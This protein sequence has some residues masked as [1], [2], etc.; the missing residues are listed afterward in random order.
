MIRAFMGPQRLSMRRLEVL[1]NGSA[2]NALAK[3]A[4]KA[5]AAE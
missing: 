4:G 1:T 2:I 3:T 5:Q